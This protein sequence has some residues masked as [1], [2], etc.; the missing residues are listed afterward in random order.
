MSLPRN[1]F[2]ELYEEHCKKRGSRAVNT[3]SFGKIIRFAFPLLQTRRLGVRGQSR[4]HYHGIRVKATSPLAGLPLLQNSART[5]DTYRCA[6]SLADR[7]SMWGD[8]NARLTSAL[9]LCYWARGPGGD[10]QEPHHRL[11]PEP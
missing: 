4:Y 2:Y 7:R 6:S 5:T 11:A 3:A 9:L 10:A 8:K 1:V